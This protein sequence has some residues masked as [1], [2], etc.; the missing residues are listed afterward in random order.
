MAARHVALTRRF[1]PLAVEAMCV[2]EVVAIEGRRRNIP[3][4]RRLRTVSY[5]CGRHLFTIGIGV[6][7]GLAVHFVMSRPESRLP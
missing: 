4:L 5:I 7:G 2:L 6:L 3:G 1:W